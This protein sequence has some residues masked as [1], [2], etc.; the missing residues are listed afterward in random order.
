MN[1]FLKEILNLIN[2]INMTCKFIL[3]LFL[4]IISFHL[5]AQ[6]S[7]NQGIYAVNE[8]VIVSGAD[9]VTG[10]ENGISGVSQQISLGTN[11]INLGHNSQPGL[12]LVSFTLADNSRQT[13][14]IGIT[15]TNLTIDN[16]II[17]SNT[18]H[19]LPGEQKNIFKHN[20]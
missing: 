18:S 9:L 2:T 20:V 8:D 19:T 12:Y 5:N 3:S 10:V 1:F 7:F 16:S 14:L 17:D 6:I 4:T 13:Y 11:N 15:N